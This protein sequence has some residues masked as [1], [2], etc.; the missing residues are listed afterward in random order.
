[1]DQL[2]KNKRNEV[3]AKKRA[4]G[5]AGN[6]PFLVCLLPLN[7]S[8][9]PQS[10]LYLLE[11]CDPEAEVNRTDSGVVYITLPRFKQRFTFVIPPVGRGTE[12][13]TLDYLK[14]CDTTVL[15]LSANV[16]T[17]QESLMDNWG[18]RIYNM[19]MSQGIPTP[20]FAVQDLESIAPKKRQQYKMAIQKSI[21][22]MIPDE[23]IMLLD[24]DTD[25]LNLMRKIGAGKKNVQHNRMNR[26]HLYGEKVEYQ[27][28]T[29]KVT[30]YLRGVPLDVNELVHIPGLG[31]FQMSQIDGP[32]DPFPIE[33]RSAAAAT[34]EGMSTGDVRVL[35]VADPSQQTALD[36]ENIPDEMDQEQP[37]PTEEEIA[38]AQMEN[39]R[40]LIKRVP[41]GTSSYQACWIPEAEEVDCED[42]DDDDDLESD[43]DD[44]FMSCGSEKETEKGEGSEEEEDGGE[45]YEEM[46]M[47]G[48]DGNDLKYD[49]TLDIQ[50][51]V[52]TLSK[53]KAANADQQWPDELDTPLDRA[54]ASRFEKYRGLESFRTSPWDIKENLPR[55]YARIFQFKNFDRTKRR[56]IAQAKESAGVST[57]TYVTVHIKNVDAQLWESF[58]SGRSANQGL[59]LYGMLPHEHKMSVINCV[60]KRT[61]DSEIPIPSKQRMVVQCGYRRFIVNPIFSQHTNGDKHKFERFFRPGETVVATFF[62][63]IQFS[64]APVLC[65]RENPDTSLT[66]VANGVLMSCTPDRVV[67]KRVVL[68]GHPYKINRKVA[69]IRYMF[70]NKE[71]V[72]YFKPIKLRTKCGRVG[73]IKE[74]LGTHG[75]MKC[76]FDGQLK[77]YD[78]VLMYL[79]KRVFPKWTYTDCIQ[80]VKAED[81]G[82][83]GGSAMM[84]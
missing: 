6:A 56:I 27:D 43:E 66:M 21:D 5:T 31:D 41:K 44:E 35:A 19:A 79:Y 9:D 29:L 80:Q 32:A 74:S 84:E 40:K 77:S 26:P 14:V 54:A 17:E 37:F 50:E 1:M 38:A 58:Q 64:P 55:D 42:D 83:T 72:E 82:K 22:K 11:K 34:D 12:L 7:A 23:K 49:E 2:R 25:A 62:A 69:T 15:L 24:T 46:A 30:G 13:T 3:I 16:N 81:E 39:K 4:L 59:V 60:L 75:H 28:N 45:E 18:N 10:A 36:R 63:P 71:D 78:T 51:E 57:G 48:Q 20:I 61:P 73:H 65:F 47:E 68:S 52:D 53:I 67:L 8:I 70:F 76:V 33:K